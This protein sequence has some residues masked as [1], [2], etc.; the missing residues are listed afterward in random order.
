[1]KFATAT[2]IAI[3]A[4]VACVG[5]FALDYW[6]NPQLWHPDK[7]AAAAP[8]Q[9]IRLT[10]WMNQLRCTE[11]FDTVRQALRMVPGID[12]AS[13]TP[14]KKLL[15]ESEAVQMTGPLP[16]YSNKVQIQITDPTKLDFVALDRAL[17]EKG[18]VADRIEV[19]GIPHFRLEAS[20]P[21]LCA[22][23]C[24]SATRTQMETLKAQEMNG[25]LAWLDSVDVD[26]RRKAVT[27]Y[28]RYL[29]PGKTVDITEFE[30]AV[31]RAG[32][33]PS[34]VR[35]LPG[36]TSPVTTETHAGSRSDV[37]HEHNAGP[38]SDSDH[39]HADDMNHADHDQQQAH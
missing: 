36:D 16:D 1:M 3:I 18:F 9:G 7:V 39:D 34:S 2:Q 31:V 14:E 8:E 30:S 5:L 19:S 38:M 32:Y 6:K 17:R 28:A 20:L 22:G 26:A 15:S 21:Y 37:G 33:A 4:V 13:A 10:L 12:A 35:L 23:S 24:E 27:A 11:C 25:Q 29:E